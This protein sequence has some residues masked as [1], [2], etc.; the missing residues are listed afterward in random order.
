MWGVR[1]DGARVSCPRWRPPPRLEHSLAV[2]EA[3]SALGGGTV[4]VAVVPVAVVSVSVVSV[5]VGGTVGDPL[6]DVHQDRID[7]RGG[8]GTRIVG[9]LLGLARQLP[10]RADNLVDR[11]LAPAG[12]LPVGARR[13]GDQLVGLLLQLSDPRLRCLRKMLELLGQRD[14]EGAQLVG[15]LLGLLLQNRPLA[16]QLADLLGGLLLGVGERAL[17]ARLRG[18]RSGRRP[19]TAGCSPTPAPTSWPGPNSVWSGIAFLLVVVWV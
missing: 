6:L 2:A 17:R 1:P 8:V 10:G 13:M 5:A 4:P 16:G 3:D 9:P 18:R 7:G 11:L 19:R 15:A 12:Q 14:H